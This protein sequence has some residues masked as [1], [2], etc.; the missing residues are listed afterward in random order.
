[1]ML[2]SSAVM[3]GKGPRPSQPSKALEYL[4]WL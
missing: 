2:V 4:Y 3:M 1:M